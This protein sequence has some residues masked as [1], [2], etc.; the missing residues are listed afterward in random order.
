MSQYSWEGNRTW[1]FPISW[2]HQDQRRTW[3]VPRHSQHLS[4][5]FNVP[6]FMALNVLPA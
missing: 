1:E 2:S 4:M 5:V 3:E 6:E